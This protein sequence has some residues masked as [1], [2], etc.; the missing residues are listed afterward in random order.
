MHDDQRSI[1]HN[2]T[3]LDAPDDAG[4][5]AI[6]Y[7]TLLKRCADED[8][9]WYKDTGNYVN[10]EL[11]LNFRPGL[12]V[13]VPVTLSEAWSEMR[14][15]TAVVRLITTFRAQKWRVTSTPFHREPN[16]E[17]TTALTFSPPLPPQVG[18]LHAM[19]NISAWDVGY[20]A[21]GSLCE[22]FGTWPRAHPDWPRNLTDATITDMLR[23]KAFFKPGESQEKL[24]AEFA[25]RRLNPQLLGRLPGGVIRSKG[26]RGHD[27]T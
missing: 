25:R 2:P 8:D 21:N 4:F 10:S 20:D 17:W 13:E 19:A 5:K 9:A 18:P 27:R 26:G 7:D 14:C 23:A 22:D 1:D 6:S 11:A 24:E 12:P 15:S 16:G 3:Q